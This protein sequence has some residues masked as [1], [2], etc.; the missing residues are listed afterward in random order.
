[1]SLDGATLYRRGSA[2]PGEQPNGIAAQYQLSAV[3]GLAST[4]IH[5]IATNAQQ[6]LGGPVL[7]ITG[8]VQPGGAGKPLIEARIQ[9][10][11]DL[12]CNN[13]PLGNTLPSTAGEGLVPVQNTAQDPT[14]GLSLSPQHE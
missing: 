6:T 11:T 8:H 10:A 3:K 13:G 12:V 14:A 1:M 2:E 7:N 5:G 9:D 4:A